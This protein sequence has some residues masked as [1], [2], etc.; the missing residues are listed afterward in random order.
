[1][2]AVSDLSGALLDLYVAKAEGLE[3]PEIHGEGDEAVVVY[4]HHEIPDDDGQWRHFMPSISWAD[5]GPLID[6]Y[7]VA[8]M[9]NRDGSWDAYTEGRCLHFGPEGKAEALGE[10][11]QIAVCRAVVAHVFGKEVLDA[12]V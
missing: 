6:K 5:A 2:T 10:T 11:V 12:G 7:H 4:L 9:R 3:F 1:M 8:V